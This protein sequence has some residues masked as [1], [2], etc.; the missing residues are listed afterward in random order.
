[1]NSIAA[2]CMAEM[3]RELIKSSLQIHVGKAF[4]KS[5]GVEYEH[6]ALGIGVLLLYWLILFWM[7]RRKIF[8]KV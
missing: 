4:F 6:F 8:L 7:Y 5:W 3:F 2:Y 1:M